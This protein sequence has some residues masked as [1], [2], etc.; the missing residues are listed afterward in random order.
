MSSKK[1]QE[2]LL[3]ETE[4]SLDKAIQVC[5]AAENIKIQTKE[6]KGSLELETNNDLVNKKSTSENTRSSSTRSVRKGIQNRKE[7]VKDCKYC[8]YETHTPSTWWSAI[9]VIMN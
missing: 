8:C 4:L 2:P 3:R 7:I 6:M 9:Y 5:R 1:V